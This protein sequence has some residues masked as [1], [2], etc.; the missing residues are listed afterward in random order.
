MAMTPKLWSISGL[1]AEL[2]MDR[3][4]VAARLR[5]LPPDGTLPGGHGGWYMANVIGLLKSGKA[6][7]RAPAPPPIGAEVLAEIKNPT[8]AGLVAGMLVGLYALPGIVREAAMAEE[9]DPDLAGRIAAEASIMMMIHYEREA[10]SC[11][12]VPFQAESP[13]WVN[14]ECFTW[15][16]TKLEEF[17]ALVLGTGE[18]VR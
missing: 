6:E 3:R 5:N 13:E 15:R 1:A 7:R 18:E 4:T 9:V 12:I 11:G 14:P 16:P 8:H 2:D 17:P 10:R